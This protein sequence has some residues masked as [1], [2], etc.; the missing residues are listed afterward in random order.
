VYIIT[1]LGGYFRVEYKTSRRR[2]LKNLD[3]S[4]VFMAVSSD[5][6]S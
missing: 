4:F 3:L 6:W 2:V 5:Y 1:F